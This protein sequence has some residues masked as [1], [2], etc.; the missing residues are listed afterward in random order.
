VLDALEERNLRENTYLVVASDNGYMLGEK[1]TFTKFQLHEISL[2]VPLFIAGPGIA[3]RLV[4]EPVSL[5]DLYPTL[6]G[7]AGLPIPPQ[8]DGQDLSATLFSGTA[9]SRASALSYT[10]FLRKETGQLYLHS[11]V[12]TPQWRLISYTPI[13]WRSYAERFFD[14]VE[15]Y[16]HDPASPGYDPNEWYNI[17]DKR[18]DVVKELRAELPD[19][20]TLMLTL[21]RRSDHED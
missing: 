20:Q 3:P 11:T 8:C 19:P 13:G 15:L 2:R 1:E 4:R 6:C 17:A 5:I 10:G 21:S 14:E 16:D 18:P 9:P 7:L 12:R